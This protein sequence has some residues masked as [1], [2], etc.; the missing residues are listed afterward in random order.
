MAEQHHQDKSQRSEKQE[1]KS[2]ISSGFPL[3]G[4][5]AIDAQA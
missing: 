5:K 4:L 2:H 3:K 1:G